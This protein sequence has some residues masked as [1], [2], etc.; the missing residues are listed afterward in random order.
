[1]DNQYRTPIDFESW[2]S[3]IGDLLAIRRAATQN[4]TPQET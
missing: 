4:Y 1:V 3:G 2:L